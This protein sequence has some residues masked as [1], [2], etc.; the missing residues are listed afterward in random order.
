VSIVEWLSDGS[1]TL[2]LALVV[3]VGLVAALLETVLGLA[4]FVPAGP[5][6]LVGA[7]SLD[8]VPGILL[9]VVTAAVGRVAGDWLAFRAGSARGAHLRSS[10]AVARLGT[11]NWDAVVDVLARRGSGPVLLTRLV[12]TA[13]Q[14]SPWAAGASG[15]PRAAFLR[16]S[17]VAAVAW[18]VLWVAVGVLTRASFPVAP[19]YLGI[20]GAAVVALLVAL[21]IVYLVGRALLLRLPEGSPRRVLGDTSRAGMTPHQEG[22]STSLRHRLF[23]EDDWRTIPN[24][25]SAVRILLLPV[26][27]ILLVVEHYWTAIV[28]LLVVFLTDFVDGFIA[29]RFDQM[30]ALGAW[31]DPI[32]DRLTVVFVVAAFAASGIVPWQLVVILLV[33]DLLSGAWAVAAFHGAPDVRVSKVGK[34]RTALTF[35]GLFLILFG[36]AVPPFRDGLVGV[37]FALFVLGVVGH[38]LAMTRNARGLITLW[39]RA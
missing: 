18:S 36:E 21:G 23:E 25:V 12:P 28:V 31:L 16:G 2:P 8:T 20:S 15:A 17:A 39:Q 19:H 1:A 24:L 9:L 32:A 30:S 35:V 3:V 4:V 26:F 34:V 13:R 29:R 5:I 7:A 37:G 38:Y 33:P 14:L 6:V 10:A 27:G 11:G 22:A